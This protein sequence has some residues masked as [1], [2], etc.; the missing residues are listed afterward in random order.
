MNY[1]G[2]IY[3]LKDRPIKSNPL[4][5]PIQHLTS[6]LGLL[7]GVST[8]FKNPKE[9]HMKPTARNTLTPWSLDPNVIGLSKGNNWSPISEQP[10]TQVSHG[11]PVRGPQRPEITASCYGLNVCYK[12][13]PHYIILSLLKRKTVTAYFSTRT[14]GSKPS[15]SSL[16]KLLQHN[17]LTIVLHFTRNHGFWYYSHGKLLGKS[18]KTIGHIQDTWKLEKYDENPMTI[19]VLKGFKE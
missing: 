15:S 9:T 3:Y 17:Q 14:R 13:S 7:W 19:T 5:Y 4:K 8:L 18:S 2:S 10:S 11:Q 1:L 16:F 6:H 12:W